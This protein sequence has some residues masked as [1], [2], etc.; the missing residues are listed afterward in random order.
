MSSYGHG[1]RHTVMFAFDP[2]HCIAVLPWQSSSTDA[3]VIRSIK[4]HVAP[5][6]QITLHAG[7]EP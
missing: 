3:S 7:L 5:A 1:L 2:V 6:S 4:M